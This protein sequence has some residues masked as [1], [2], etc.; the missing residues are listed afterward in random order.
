MRQKRSITFSILMVLA[1]FAVTN[2]AIAQDAKP[3]KSPKATIS[4]RVG[5]DTDIVIDYSRPGVKGRTIWGEL[6]PYG[7]FPGNKYS[8]EKPFPWRA[9]ANENTTISFN[10]DVKIEGKAIPAGKYSIH[11]IAG[12]SEFKIMFNKVNDEWGSYKY[13]ASKDALVIT[14]KPVSSAHTEWLE[15]G[16]EDLSDTGATVYLQ[17]E[18]LKIPFKLEL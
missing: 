12:K 8:N 3:R 4:Q 15:F 10:H 9:G 6:V 18:K 7:L 5:V 14:V 16:F 11:M 1:I 13:D 2:L 17:W